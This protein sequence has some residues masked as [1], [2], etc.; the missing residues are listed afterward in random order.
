MKPRPNILLLFTDEQKLSELSA[1]GPTPCVTPNLDRL[2][3][4]ST[5]F[6][7]AYTSC[8]LCSPARATIMTGLYPHGHGVTCNTEDIG[9][10]VSDLPDHPNLLSRR[11]G[12]TG[13]VC[14]YTGKWHLGRSHPR[15]FGTEKPRALP[16]NLGFVGQDFP[17]HGGGG[18][19]YPAYQAYLKERGLR[20]SVRGEEDMHPL[21]YGVLDGPVE[22]T[23]PYFLAEHTISLID[24][25]RKG[26]APFFIWHNFWGPHQPY[27]A[28]KRYLEL[29][30]SV[31]IP[32]WANYDHDAGTGNGP[33]ALRRHPR[34]DTVT[35]AEW[36]HMI[37]HKYAFMT[38]IDE[39]IGRILDHLRVAGLLDN[40]VV[41]FTADHGD[42]LGCHGGLIDKGFSHYEE[43]HRI[44]LF[45]RTP[46]SS[47]V[48]V[49]DYASL[50]DVYPTVLD[51]AR[52]DGP[53]NVHGRALTSPNRPPRNYV[54]TEFHGLNNITLTM[55][56]IRQGAIKYGYTAGS[57]HELYDLASD[58]H[59]IRNLIDDPARRPEL[60][61]LR[62]LLLE[63]MQETGDPLA[64]QFGRYVQ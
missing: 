31:T 54:V 9:C 2:A 25:F 27:Y 7:N 34:Q 14:G 41:I 52:T 51:L 43:T 12:Q 28:P 4:E 40:T 23:V 38:L 6:E 37:K 17:G 44:P 5:I 29:Y 63:W 20:H 57:R 21:P 48:R 47:P 1:Y 19:H 62:R 50:A 30:D 3:A 22:S 56:T 35:W 13:Y 16:S 39:Q 10:N 42:H 8:P 46:G 15:H 26:E 33:Q 49:A 61:R 59:E 11:L 60:L 58:P 45:L 55:R 53:D 64:G 32:E 36:E 24:Q 18:F